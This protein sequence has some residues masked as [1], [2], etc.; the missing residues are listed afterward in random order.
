[1]YR[2]FLPEKKCYSD[3]VPCF[4]AILR[5]HLIWS[6]CHAAV[7]G[8]KPRNQFSGNWIQIA[9]SAGIFA[10]VAAVTNE[11]DRGKTRVSLQKSWT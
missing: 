4:F 9:G 7:T 10:T 11:F 1:L 6:L 5:L 8:V 3:I 2:K